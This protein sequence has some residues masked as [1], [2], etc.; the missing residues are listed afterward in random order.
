MI[1]LGIALLI[2][3]LVSLIMLIKLPL[4]AEGGSGL[5]MEQ[6]IYLLSLSVLFLLL[7][8]SSTIFGYYLTI[9]FIDTELSVYDWRFTLLGT[10]FFGSY[11]AALLLA[12]QVKVSHLIEKNYK[13]EKWNLFQVAQIIHDGRSSI[14]TRMGFAW[15]L[16]FF[17]HLMLLLT[18]SLYGTNVNYLETTQDWLQWF[19]TIFLFIMS[20]YLPLRLI[21]IQR[22][23]IW[24]KLIKNRIITQIPDG[25][26][27]RKRWKKDNF[28]G[29]DTVKNSDGVPI[30]DD[31]GLP[32]LN[33]PL[34][35]LYEGDERT[36]EQFQDSVVGEKKE[37]E[38]LPLEEEKEGIIEQTYQSENEEINREVYE[39]EDLSQ[40]EKSN[41]KVD[42][43]KLTKKKRISIKW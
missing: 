39:P 32:Q 11:S 14:L 34:P 29:F 8:L 19:Y 26:L 12:N 28:V 3:S 41:E 42:S 21:D 43:A 15:S 1:V 20:I 35:P 27:S 16:L 6:G 40:S 24:K 30:L 22:T 10:V 25:Q 17:F 13:S 37:K 33:S 9:A 4:Y 38:P 18:V 23:G 2:I 7:H 5:M 36:D 31:E